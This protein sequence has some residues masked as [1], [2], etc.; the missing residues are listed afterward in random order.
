MQN[1]LFFLNCSC[2]K[3]SIVDGCSESAR[4]SVALG[5]AF[6]PCSYTL[7]AAFF[8]T[9]FLP[10]RRALLIK[11]VQFSL[12][13]SLARVTTARLREIHEYVNNI[14]D[15]RLLPKQTLLPCSGIF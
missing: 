4:S 6:Q 5:F 1:I 9:V 12:V 14:P 15:H 3:S 11:L 8:L 13:S 10:S 2:S 7:D